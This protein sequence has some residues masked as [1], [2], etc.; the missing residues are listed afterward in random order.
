M[1]NKQPI[2]EW[3]QQFVDNLNKNAVERNKKPSRKER[4]E[5]ELAKKEK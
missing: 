4:I 1:E 3:V 5:K 2:P